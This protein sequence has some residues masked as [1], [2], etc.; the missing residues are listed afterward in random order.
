MEHKVLGVR[1][2]RM[3]AF[4]FLLGFFKMEQRGMS[5]MFCPERKRREGR[6]GLGLILVVPVSIL[7]I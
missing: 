7:Y 3:R 2:E 6:G 1:E 5:Y 4:S